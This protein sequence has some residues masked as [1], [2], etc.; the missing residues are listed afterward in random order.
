MKQILAIGASNSKNS[1]N[2]A[3]ANYTAHQI[4]ESVVTTLDLN[5]FEM[6][7]YSVD[8]ESEGGIPPQAKAFFEA[9]QKS[10]AI[11]LSFAEHN[12]SYSAAFK[13]LLDWT[14]RID[15]KLWQSKPMLLLAT[16]PGGR[17]GATVLESAKQ[18]LPHLGAK[19]LG[20][21]ALPS[22]YEKFSPEKGIIDPQL[23]ESFAKEFN[24]LA[25]TI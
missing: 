16:S 6:P 20:S 25:Q 1:I 13:N 4:P 23:N 12:G 21:F 14:S 19:V 11:V 8:R 9:I 15:Q 17:G 10:N 24:L 7:L 5:D 3:F 18:T 22:Y 2:K